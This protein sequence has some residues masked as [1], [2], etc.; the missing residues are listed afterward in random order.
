M[1][2]TCFQIKQEVS[3]DLMVCVLNLIPIVSILPSVLA[4]SLV[5]LEIQNFKVITWPWAEA[6]E[7]KS[8]LCL[9]WC[10]WTFFK[11]RC[12]VFTKTIL[13]RV[14]M[15]LWLRDLWVVSP[16]Q[17][18]W[19]VEASPPV[20]HTKVKLT[21]CYLWWSLVKCNWKYSLVVV[22]IQWF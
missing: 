14:P 18:F 15:N 20:P 12:N 8:R 2:M 4:E 19:W 22:K 21:P 5:K 1:K 6:S 9:V 13:Y 10:S 7:G 16:H 3:D 11:W 17:Q